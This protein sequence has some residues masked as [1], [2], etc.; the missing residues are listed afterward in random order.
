MALAPHIRKKMA[1]D[2]AAA[3]AI[4]GTTT[5]TT[6][7]VNTA[8]TGKDQLPKPA[9]ASK[10]VRATHTDSGGATAMAQKHI[11]NESK[12]SDSSDGIMDRSKA[13]AKKRDAAMKPSHPGAGY[14]CYQNVK[15]D[16]DTKEAD[17]DDW[18]AINED[19]L[20]E[21]EYDFCGCAE[22]E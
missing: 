17:N 20:D 6:A 15:P 4:T 11:G 18:V 2:A 16:V 13:F 22:K 7:E 10:L 19:D 8:T 12:T 9:H 5:A 14:E 3:A 21:A 1:E